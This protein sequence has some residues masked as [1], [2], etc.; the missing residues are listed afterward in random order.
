MRA[1]I[2]KNVELVQILLF[3][4][5][6][7]DKTFQCINN[8][9]YINSITE[10]F[11][12][13]KNHTAVKLTREL[14][15]NNNFVHIEPLR[16]IL[17]L[18]SIIMDTSHELHDWGTAVRQFITDTDFD[19]FF[20]EQDSYYKWIIDNIDSCKTDEWI[21][22]IQKYFRQKPDEF[23]LII[24]PIKGN[25]G[26]SLNENGKQTA[27]TVR[28]MPKYDKDGNYT[29]EYDHFAKG[30]A[31]EYAHCFV[32][33]TVELHTDL[34]SR[35]KDFF[36][37]HINIPNFY[38][39][40]FAIINEYFVR[41]FQIRFMELNKDSFPDFDIQKEYFF[42]KESFIFIDK[43]ISALMLFEDMT[44]EF[45]EFYMDNIDEIL[46]GS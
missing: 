27:Y 44:V 15:I 5:D 6:Q 43:F 38:N 34:L 45:S 25:Y 19:I 16:A 14:V 26:F 1:E 46:S 39:T 18:N 28:F 40:D 22:F 31:H 7:H 33:P 10:W 17:S 36:D 23:K 24:S 3:L 35:H 12:P 8:K 11:A 42:Q 32:N 41:A 29:F 13:F 4:T 20:A 2:N 21:N 9:T 37:K 30:I